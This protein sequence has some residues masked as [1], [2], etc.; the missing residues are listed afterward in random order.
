MEWSS[1][2]HARPEA[3]VSH[4]NAALTPR[5]RARLGRFLVEKGFT[6]SEAAKRFDGPPSPGRVL[7][8]R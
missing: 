4:A 5:A 3:F 1:R 6:V 2:N 7:A 8:P